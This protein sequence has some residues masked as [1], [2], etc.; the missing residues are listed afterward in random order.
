M[1]EFL[2]FKDIFT[3]DIIQERLAEGY[4][5]FYRNHKDDFEHFTPE[6]ERL[7]HQTVKETINLLAENGIEKSFPIKDY[8]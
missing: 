3:E 5:D 1:V 8:L 4:N 6:Q 7:I 2:G